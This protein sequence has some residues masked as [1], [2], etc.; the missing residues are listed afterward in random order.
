MISVVINTA[1]LGEKAQTVLSSGGVPHG[2]RAGLLRDTIIPIVAHDPY[3]YELAVVGEFCSGYGYTYVHS[4]SVNFDCTDA[5]VSRAKGVR[6]THGRVIVFLHDDHLPLPGFFQTIHEKYRDDRSWDVLVPQRVCRK[7]DA[8]IP[9][10]NG[11]TDY[12]MGHASVMH[13]AAASLVPWDTIPK[14]FAWDVAH[15]DRLREMQAVIRWVDDLTVQDMETEL[16][17]EP[18]R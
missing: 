14:V 18:W 12:V 5:L 11:A 2:A 10:N 8:V 3:V 17:A 4:P 1:A 13:R 16:G 6:A 15:T 7:G 9:L